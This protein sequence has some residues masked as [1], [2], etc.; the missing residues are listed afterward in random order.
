MISEK[1]ISDLY[2]KYSRRPKSPDELDFALLF[3]SVPD[4]QAF[5]VDGTALIINALEPE[6]PFHR[7][8][9]KCIHSIVNCG[10]SV[11]IVLHSSIIFINKETGR[12]NVH[13]NFRDRSLLQRIFG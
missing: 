5:K 9:L 13:I 1:N 3:E 6:S 10:D 8:P 7:I 2:R 4:E 11:A 12:V